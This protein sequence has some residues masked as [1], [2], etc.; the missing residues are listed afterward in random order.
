MELLSE[1]AEGV[2]YLLKDR[3]SDVDDFRAAVRRVAEGGSALDPAVVSQ[4]VGRRRRD[5][6]LGELTPR[7]REVLELMAE[8]RSNHAIADQLVVTER[9]I[10]KHVTSIFAKLRPRAGARGP[11]PRPRRARVPAR[12][13]SRGRPRARPP[14]RDLTPPRLVTNALRAAVAAARRTARTPCGCRTRDAVRHRDAGAVRTWDGT[15]QAF[16][17]EGEPCHPSKRSNNIAARMGR[18]SASHWKTAVFGWLA[19]VARRRS[20]SE[21]RSGRSRSTND[22]ASV[23]ESHR[24]EQ[25]LKQSGFS[26]PT[27]RRSSWSSRARRSRSDDP[28][29]RGRRSARRRPRRRGRSR[30]CNNLR[31]PLDPGHGDLVSDDGRTV[32]VAVGDEGHARRGREEDRPDRRGDRARRQRASGLLR[33][34]GRG[35]Q[36]RQGAERDVRR[37]ARAGRRAVDPADADRAAAR[38]RRASSRRPCRSSLALTGVVGDDRAPRDPEPAR[39]RWTRTSPQSSCSSASP[40]ASTTR[41]ST[42]SASA[43][44]APPARATAPRS[45]QPRDVGPVGPHL[46]HHRDGRDGRDALLRRQDVLLVRHRDDDGR[47]HRDDRLAD[48]AAGAA[49]QAR[50]PHREGPHPV[51]AAASAARA[52]RTASGRRS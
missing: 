49:R 31:S 15:S 40:S 41:S 28:A 35:G 8:G 44:S 23:G 16:N 29:F 13:G 33:R 37:A 2:G 22:D 42:S 39:S 30:R 47:R 10:E 52:G 27:R 17:L 12:L 21:C 5:D 48:G 7:E 18:W 36:L 26:S 24:A 38:V 9:A 25:I 46:G 3:I 34:R 51:P 20:Q 50:R 4:L 19:F 11:P 14:L 43:R 32:M 45:R 6:P 1:S